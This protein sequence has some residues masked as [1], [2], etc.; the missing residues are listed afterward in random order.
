MPID[1]DRLLEQSQSLANPVFRVW[2]EDRKRAQVEVVGAEVGGQPR[3]GA[4][5]LGR[6]QCRLDDPGDADRDPVLQFEHVFE[7]A[8]EAVGPEMRT[9]QGIDQ[10]AGDAHLR[11]GF[12]H[13]AFEHIADA[14]L[15]PDLFHV[16]GLAL[17]GEARIPGDD[18]EP[19]DAGVP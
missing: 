18:K 17:V 3:G 12:A 8:V 2:K 11:S 19:A 13:R 9:G 16:D 7:R 14:E 10:L 15:A 1:R 6:L 5:H 4:A